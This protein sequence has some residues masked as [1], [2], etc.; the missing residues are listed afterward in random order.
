MGEWILPALGIPSR[1]P[2]AANNPSVTIGIT[3]SDVILII[4]I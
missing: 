2:A 4:T 3:S 1:N